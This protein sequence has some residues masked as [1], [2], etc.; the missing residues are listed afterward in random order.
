RFSEMLGRLIWDIAALTARTV[1]LL[2][3]IGL[4]LSRW[5]LIAT[6]EGL[7]TTG[8]ALARAFLLLTKAAMRALVA[9]IIGVAEAFE[10]ARL[11][12]ARAFAAALRHTKLAL[13]RFGDFLA[14]LGGLGYRHAG[15][16]AYGA[17]VGVSLTALIFSVALLTEETPGG[18]TGTGPLVAVTDTPALKAAPRR[19]D[20]QPPLPS[21]PLPTLRADLVKE[22]TGIIEPLEKEITAPLPEEIVPAPAQI[23]IAPLPEKLTPPI[24]RAS[25]GTIPRKTPQGTRTGPALMAIVID[26][27]GMKRNIT[28]PFAALPGPLTFAFLPYA[29]DL[30]RQT[31]RV[32]EAGHELFVHLPMEPQSR[33]E[34][35]GPNALLTGLTD[36]ELLGRIEWNLNRFE[37]FVGIN[38][39]MG[40]LFTESRKHMLPVIR[41]MVDRKLVY[42]DSRTSPKTVGVD[43]AKEMG[44]RWINRDIFLDNERTREA[45]DRQ[46][47]KAVQMAKR[48]GQVIAIGH[49]YGVTL[50]AL[51]AWLPLA[52]DKGVRLVTVSELVFGGGKI[53]ETFAS[54]GAG[55]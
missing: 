12:S 30:K 36:Q 49:N 55:Q 41:A 52:A 32:R 11:A 46:L 16:L 43:L 1:G 29:G 8:L 47:A 42:L 18:E 53:D 6:A 28:A 44:V 22:A 39:H 17:V 7:L 23:R 37:G 40:S 21:K 14:S 2:T 13:A 24:K 26:D 35:P 50:K 5:L 15:G 27:M 48:R 38:N 54:A 19:A 33:I 4:A 3:M 9:A 20:E 45:I 34:D 25:R 51:Q 10:R 31:R